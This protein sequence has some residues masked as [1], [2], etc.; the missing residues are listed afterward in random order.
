[1]HIY[2]IPPPLPH[3]DLSIKKMEK[4]LDLDFNSVYVECTDKKSHKCKKELGENWNSEA[5]REELIKDLVIDCQEGSYA[6]VCMCLRAFMCE[7][8]LSSSVDPSNS[9]WNKF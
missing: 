8:H 9:V 3:A 4:A 2:I 5:K 1:M 6:H 7:L